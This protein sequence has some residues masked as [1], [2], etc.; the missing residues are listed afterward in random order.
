M[1]TFSKTPISK[2]KAAAPA[3]GRNE[4]YGWET[5]VETHVDD[6]ES[7]WS[8]RDRFEPLEHVSAPPHEEA[9]HRDY[10]EVNRTSG[11]CAYVVFGHHAQDGIFRNWSSCID[12]LS[13]TYG[14]KKNRPFYKGFKVDGE[15]EKA[16]NAFKQSGQIPRGLIRHGAEMPVARPSPQATPMRPAQPSTPT[17]PGHHQTINCSQPSGAAQRFFSP[18]PT[19]SPSRRF[20]SPLA[21]RATTPLRT[22]EEASPFQ[23]AYAG[24]QPPMAS[25]SQFP[26][27]S[28]NITTR[29]SSKNSSAHLQSPQQGPKFNLLKMSRMTERKWRES[30]S[31]APIPDGAD[32]YFVVIKGFQPGV[33]TD[34]N[35]MLDSFPETPAQCDAFRVTSRELALRMFAESFMAGAVE[36]I[37]PFDEGD[38]ETGFY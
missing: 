27:N 23:T 33:Y 37:E 7:Y 29:G 11:N 13:S 17:R 1:H 12:H 4:S 14:P 26:F 21:S 31:A 18:S 9:L 10:C 28:P 5:D 22:R 2:G 32:E 36:V 35:D 30:S 8:T 20:V 16:W 19:S 34:I 25:T 3:Q 38:Y 24:S 6:E 15:A